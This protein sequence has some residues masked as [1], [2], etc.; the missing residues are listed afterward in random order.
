VFSK[1][2]RDSRHVHGLPGED[3]MIGPEEVNEGAF[4]FVGECCLDSNMLGRV[5]V[6]DLDILRVFDGFECAE[7]GL[8]SIRSSH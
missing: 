2:P 7:N 5:D 3:V 1:F 4:L 6:V 8:G